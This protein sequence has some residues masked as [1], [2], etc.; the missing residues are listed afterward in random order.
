LENITIEI[1]KKYGTN[2]VKQFI[3]IIAIR[4][5]PSMS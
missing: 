4:K 3:V 2:S 5:L 1:E